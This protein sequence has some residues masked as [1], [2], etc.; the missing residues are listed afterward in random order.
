[1]IFNGKDLIEFGVHA[2]E[3]AAANA[4]AVRSVTTQSVPGKNGDLIFDDGRYEPV[5]LSFDCIIDSDSSEMYDALIDFLAA[6]KTYHR[7]EMLSDRAHYRM[8]YFDKASGQECSEM[9][10]QIKFTLEFVAKPQRFLKSGD[11]WTDASVLF[12][13]TRYTALPLIRAVGASGSIGIGEDTVTISS[14]SLDYIDIDCGIM[15]AYCGA[16]NANGYVSVT[17]YPTL[18]PGKNGVAKSKLSSVK[19]KPRWWEI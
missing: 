12:N 19:V 3:R 6:D 4:R 14:N 7:L 5:P 18:Q 10:S 15:N 8:A 11:I 9:F 1:M 13:P 17:D 16:I 2:D